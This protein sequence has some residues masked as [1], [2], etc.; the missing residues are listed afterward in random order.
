MV[1]VEWPGSADRPATGSFRREA[2]D[3]LVA[4]PPVKIWR[5]PIGPGWSSFAVAGRPALH[6]GAARRRRDRRLLSASTPV[7][8]CGGIATRSRFWESNGGAGPRGTPTLSNGRVYTLGAT[9][10][11]QRARRQKR[12]RHLVAQC[13]VRPGEADP[14]VGLLE[15]AAGRRRHGR[16]SPPRASWPRYELATGKPRWFGPNGGGGYSSPHLATIDGVEQIVFL[17]A[18]GA[19]SVNA[20]RRQTCSGSTHGQARPSCS[21]R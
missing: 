7:S 19:T 20:G 3:R 1:R 6:T 2:R 16:S 4:S 5:R 18:A 11:P 8:R 9:G 12:R 21:P 15:L 17:S 13:R 14:D 10:D